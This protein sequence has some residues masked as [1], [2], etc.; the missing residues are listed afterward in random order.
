[1][2]RK[3]REVTE[4]N[5]I[6]KILDSCK[7]ACVAM[8][9]GDLPYVVP[10]SYGYELEDDRL[11]LY[12]HCAREGRKLEI[13]KRSPKVCFTIFQEGELLCAET[14]CGSGYYYS[15][16][17]GNGTVSFTGDP[18]KKRHALQKMFAQQTGKTIEFTE[19][20]ADAVCVFQIVSEDYAGKRKR[21][22]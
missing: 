14:P 13:L 4:T 2:R 18:G 12:F 22:A 5:E 19:A 1:M 7:T 21:K 20:Q 11:V 15:S 3:D 10:L 17:I 9:D 8:L 16:V 6:R